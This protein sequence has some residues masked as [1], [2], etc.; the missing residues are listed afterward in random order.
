MNKRIQNKIAK[1]AD[2]PKRMTVLVSAMRRVESY[3]RNEAAMRGLDTDK[4]ATYA[5]FW[6]PKIARLAS[7]RFRC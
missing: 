7:L 1:R 6:N 3:A 5:F 4:W 2:H